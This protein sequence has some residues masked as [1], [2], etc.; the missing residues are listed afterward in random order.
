MQYDK[1]SRPPSSSLMPNTSIVL[2]NLLSSSYH[3]ET[4][5]CWG[6]RRQRGRKQM[7][8]K[9]KASWRTHKRRLIGS[10]RAEES[11]GI[12]A[13]LGHDIHTNTNILSRFLV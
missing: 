5:A 8:K 4:S 13:F 11:K 7:Y 1:M 12:L 9:P 6:Q 2:S 3:R 10:V